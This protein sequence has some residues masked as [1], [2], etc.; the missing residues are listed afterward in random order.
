MKTISAG[1]KYTLSE[2]ELKKAPTEPG[3]R[4]IWAR[5]K[6]YEKVDG[7]S[8]VSEDEQED[9]EEAYDKLIQQSCTAAG[10]SADMALLSEKANKKKTKSSC[11]S[12]IKI[13]LVDEK[14]CSANYSKCEDQANFDKYFADCGVLSTGCEAYLTDIR[15]D[16]IASRNT[17][18]EN[19][20]KVLAG[21][22]A[23]YQQQRTQKLNTTNESCKTGS[24]KRA[25][26]ETVCK[27]NMRHQCDVGYD[28]EEGL[29]NQ[30]CKFYDTACERLK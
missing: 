2:K 5:Q 24:A 7:C 10:I 3:E 18:V 19:A 14:R 23:S 9:I 30:L 1:S 21:I 15:S 25:C 12:D 22:V 8:S 6:C 26:V 27:N 28:Y 16:L 29:A 20:D 11:S 13:C 4:Y 17:A